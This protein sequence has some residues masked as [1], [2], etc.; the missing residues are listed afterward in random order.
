M[1]QHSWS[2]M[3]GAAFVTIPLA[4][5][6]I[7]KWNWLVGGRINEYL[8]LSICHVGQLERRFRSLHGMVCSRQRNLSTEGCQWRVGAGT[9][10]PPTCRSRV[11]WGC[12]QAT[13]LSGAAWNNA[14]WLL[15]SSHTHTLLF[16]FWFWFIKLF[17]NRNLSLFLNLSSSLSCA[18]TLISSFSTDGWH[19]SPW[20]WSATLHLEI[21]PD[22]LFSLLSRR[23]Y[24]WNKILRKLQGH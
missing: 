21:I 1:E 14:L 11:F 10:C 22:S 7:L 9:R 6:I 16:W 23:K 18:Y 19:P 4:L 12:R 13:G 5:C 8:N 2:E 20:R 3:D 15:V 24:S 17:T